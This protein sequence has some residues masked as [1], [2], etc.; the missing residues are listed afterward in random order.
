M[1]LLVLFFLMAKLAHLVK[2]VGSLVFSLFLFLFLFF[3][4]FFSRRLVPFV[5][6][7]FFFVPC[8]QR[9]KYLFFK[10]HHDN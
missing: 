9:L 4:I 7:F 2:F 6:L 1:F 5:L 3:V 8:H 10:P